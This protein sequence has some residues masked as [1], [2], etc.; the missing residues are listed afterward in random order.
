MKIYL[1]EPNLKEKQ[2]FHRFYYT[3]LIKIKKAKLTEEQRPF[4]RIEKPRVHTGAWS[5]FDGH[6]VFFDLSDHV[7]LFDLKALENCS[8]YFK[9]NFNRTVAR[10]VLRSVNLLNHEP[11]IVPFTWFAGNLEAYRHNT[12]RKRVFFRFI[13]EK[14]ELCYIVGVYQNPLR[15]G[16]TSPFVN[17][18][19]K[20]EPSNYHFWIRFHIAESL[21]S[22]GIS[23]IYR[24]TSRGNRLIEDG[25]HVFP[26]LFERQFMQ[27]MLAS[28]FTVINTLPHALFPWKVSE[29]LMLGKPFIV[30]RKPLVEMPEPFRP[31]PDK[32][33][34]ELLPG[35][36][37]FNAGVPLE[38]PRGYRVL[39]PPSVEFIEQRA[40]WLKAILKD[41]DRIG[42][43]QE[44]ARQYAREVLHPA[45]V[46]DFICENVQK[47]IH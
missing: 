31:L 27:A 1:Y 47:R 26:N 2:S 13:K 30:E 46:A 20:I 21:K 25:V 44:N 12:F 15:S 17:S 42:V 38:D 29:S 39:D 8:V 5:R 14:Y 22:A 23:G 11:K 43:M 16:E 35:L 28:H 40:Q 4:P 45:T 19:K 3:A 6:L 24:L 36:G 32:H 10:K 37:D 9:A 41:R 7:F 34:L 18:S 33:Y